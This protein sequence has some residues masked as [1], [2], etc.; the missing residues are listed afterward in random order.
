[1]LCNHFRPNTAIIRSGNK[2]GNRQ[3]KQRCSVDRVELR[4]CLLSFHRVKVK[5]EEDVRQYYTG[6]NHVQ[7]NISSKANFCSHGK[8]R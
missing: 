6:G 8:V 5:G 1:M 4:R 3:K 7:T 2:S